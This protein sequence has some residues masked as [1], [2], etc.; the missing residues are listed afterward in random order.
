M[1]KYQ[2]KLPI[3]PIA[4]VLVILLVITLGGALFG[5]EEK[6]EADEAVAAGIAYLES[7]EQKDPLEQG[8]ATHASILACKISRTEEPGCL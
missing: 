1:S 8:I 6:A 4:A 5:G 3:V 7:L 2:K